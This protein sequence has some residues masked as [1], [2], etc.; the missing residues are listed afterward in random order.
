M[1]KV[2]RIKS[3]ERDSIEQLRFKVRP[4]ACTKQLV[5]SP[6]HDDAVNPK[7]PS[8]NC[9]VLGNFVA[10][11]SG[12]SALPS[13][14]LDVEL[15]TAHHNLHSVSYIILRIPT[16][17]AVPA[18]LFGAY[19]SGAKPSLCARARVKEHSSHQ[20]DYIWKSGELQLGPGVDGK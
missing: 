20:M 1:P 8:V 9:F 11:C 16:L 17:R 3:I 2:S 4:V 12:Y 14:H 6:P 18:A 7:S 15:Y 10:I 13:L 19:F 5:L